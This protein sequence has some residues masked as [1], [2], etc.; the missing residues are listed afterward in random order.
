MT[1][2]CVGQAPRKSWHLLGRAE[3]AGGQVSDDRVGESSGVISWNWLAVQTVLN[4]HQ[5]GCSSEWLE[6]SVA[7]QGTRAST[8]QILLRETQ[9]RR[10][11]KGREEVEPFLDWVEFENLPKRRQCGVLLR[12]ELRSCR[13]CTWLLQRN[14][15]CRGN[16][17]RRSRRNAS[18]WRFS[19]VSNFG[20]GQALAL[21][22]IGPSKVKQLEVADLIERREW[23]GP[24][25]QV[26][27][28][29]Q[30]NLW[31]YGTL[32]LDYRRDPI[33]CP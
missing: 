15:R 14:R 19:C 23:H 7:A 11:G 6:I 27:L 9:D 2:V 22:L 24:L 25:S 29:C 33:S 30:M 16:P 21:S 5:A 20:K 4:F 8:A 1:C 26:P 12:L 32:D 17:T 31:H 10:N 3:R 18:G 28:H 13:A